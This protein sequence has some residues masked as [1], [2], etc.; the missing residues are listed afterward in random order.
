MRR[1]LAVHLQRRLTHL[2]T[3]HILLPLN[4]QEAEIAVGVRY[5]GMNLTKQTNA[6]IQRLAEALFC[7]IVVLEIKI[8]K[9]QVI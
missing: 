9:T 4:V 6:Q 1:S 8:K 2:L 7:L 5:C 3:L